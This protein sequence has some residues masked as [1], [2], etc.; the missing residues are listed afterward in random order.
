MIWFV[1]LRLN[2]SVCLSVIYVTTFPLYN[3]RRFYV[4]DL[5]RWI[6]IFCLSSQQLES[7]FKRA[8]LFAYVTVLVVYANQLRLLAEQPVSLMQIMEDSCV[9]ELMLNSTA[10][11]YTHTHVNTLAQHHVLPSSTI[12]IKETYRED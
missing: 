5:K 1:S 11:E 8:G 3:T 2:R 10:H 12:Q 7:G 6:Y 4:A 9:A